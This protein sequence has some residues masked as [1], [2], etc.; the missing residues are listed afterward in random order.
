MNDHDA[1]DER[2][3]MNTGGLLGLALQSFTGLS[4]ADRLT[5]RTTYGDTS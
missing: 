1:N 5:A 3:H 2:H 4:D